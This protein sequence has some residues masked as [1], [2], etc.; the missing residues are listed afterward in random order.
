MEEDDIMIVYSVKNYYLKDISTCSQFRIKLPEQSMNKLVTI[1]GEY[2]NVKLNCIKNRP[3]LPV[4]G[5]ILLSN[6][7]KTKVIL[8]LDEDH[9]TDFT[10]FN[11]SNVK[12]VLDIFPENITN[13]ISTIYIDHRLKYLDKFYYV[14]LYKNAPELSTLNLEKIRQEYIKPYFEKTTDLLKIGEPG[15]SILLEKFY[16]LY[17]DPISDVFQAVNK[18]I[19]KWNEWSIPDRIKFL[20]FLQELWI[21]VSDL[22]VLKNLFKI[23]NTGHYIILIGKAHYNNMVSFMDNYLCKLGFNVDKLNFIKIFQEEIEYTGEKLYECI[24]SDKLSI[25][26]PMKEYEMNKSAFYRKPPTFNA[27]YEKILNKKK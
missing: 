26:I 12:E 7:V 8:E 13:N 27:V 10:S 14:S 15:Y 11:I 18:D 4:E 1:F 3:I 6:S 2:H 17:I 16:K 23:D 19:E 24:N 5:F 9:L 20:Y 22:F 25:T 21:K